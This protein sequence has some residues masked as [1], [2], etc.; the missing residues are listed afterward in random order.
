[1]QQL[2]IISTLQKKGNQLFIPNVPEL[3]A[4]LRKV[5]RAKI[6]DSIFVQSE[7][8]EKIRYEMKIIHRTDKDLEGEIIG[9]QF[10][11]LLEG[12]G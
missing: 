12:G 1:M 6:G 7:E 2:F 9:T 8:G 10:S 5:L 3:L 11:P 4:Q